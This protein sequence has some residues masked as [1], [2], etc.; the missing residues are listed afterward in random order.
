MSIE[1]QPLE[2][3]QRQGGDQ[4]ETFLFYEADFIVEG[5][6][7]LEGNVWANGAPY[8]NCAGWTPTH[9]AQRNA[10]EPM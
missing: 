10:P 8:D 5:W 9:W 6:M 7:D 4:T 3:C 1:W 2:T